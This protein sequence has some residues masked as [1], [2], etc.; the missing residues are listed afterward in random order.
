MLRHHTGTVTCNMKKEIPQI[1]FKSATT[2]NFYFEIVPIEKISNRNDPNKH[3]SE[4]PHQLKFCNLFF[5]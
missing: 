1:A 3:N 5:L 2:E 4:I